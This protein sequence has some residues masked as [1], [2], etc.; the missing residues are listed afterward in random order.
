MSWEKVR[1]GDICLKIASGATPLGGKDNYKENGI[2]LIRSLNVHDFKF[3]YKDL[4]F[5]D[6]AQSKK[7]SNVVV[8]KNDILL[9]ITGASV[10]RCTMVPVNILP[11]RV[12]Q[13]VMI[14]RAN[15]KIVNP[16]F[17]LYLI[18]ST[19]YKSKLMMLSET[20][21]TREALTKDDISNFQIKYPSLDI[22][23]KIA[24][25]LSNYDNLIENNTKR[26][27]LLEEMAEEL[28]KEWF[29]RLRFP[30]YENT[31]IINGIPE[32]W[33]EK[34]FSSIIKLL[35][36]YAF[37]SDDFENETTSKIVVRMGNFKIKGGLKFDSNIKYLNENVQV[38]KQHYLSEGDML[39]VLSDVTRE[40]SII[41]NVGLV[42]K[43]SKKYVLN[44]RVSKLIFDDHLKFYL[45][46][47]FNGA[48]FKNYCL[49][50]ADSATVLNLSNQDLYKHKMIIPQKAIIEKFTHLIKPINFEI[51]TLILKNQN[52]KETRD[53]LLSRLLSGKLNIEDLDIV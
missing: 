19:Q 13:H 23:N 14:I 31:K 28:Y 29:V 38:K 25:I 2:S 15:I 21:A 34:S 4:A 41:G 47:Y 7:L 18:N 12:N 32:G 5:I 37:K 24:N 52:L 49:A 51:D 10:G 39:I 6:T 46:S 30:N 16:Y 36:G 3:L 22:Q 26:I 11:A 35:S 43:S 9:N 40:G 27:K 44:Q 48:I 42:P 33:E 45:Y 20:G 8:E 50:H 17:L 1:L 53:L